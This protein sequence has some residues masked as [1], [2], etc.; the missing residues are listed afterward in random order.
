MKWVLITE[1]WYESIQVRNGPS[2]SKPRPTP[3]WGGSATTG[4]MAAATRLAR[5]AGRRPGTG[6]K[7]SSNVPALLDRLIYGILAAEAALIG[8]GVTP[9]VGLRAYL[10]ATRST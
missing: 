10:A 9:P 6:D 4:S 3:A 5:A 7:R 1:I 2:P 8:R